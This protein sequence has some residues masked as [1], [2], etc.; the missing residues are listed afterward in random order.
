MPLPMFYSIFLILY[1]VL[2]IVW[3][4][5]LIHSKK[6]ICKVHIFMT[7]TLIFKCG[8]L[9][10]TI[11]DYLYIERYG[12]SLFNWSIVVNIISSLNN[13]FFYTTL[14]LVSMG[15]SIIKE[16]IGIRL[17]MSLC[18]L[19]LLQLSII[20]CGILDKSKF[21]MF[22]AY[23]LFYGISSFM[24]STIILI[25]LFI[26]ISHLKKETKVEGKGVL[27][28]RKLALYKQMSIVTAFYFYCYYPICFAVKIL[29]F[30]Y[31]FIQRFALEIL[32]ICYYIY[33]GFKF[34]P[35]KNNIYYMLA[36]DDSEEE[37]DVM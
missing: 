36:M 10:V 23:N 1:I 31:E 12:S 6:S 15:Y 29:P 25:V 19:I 37:E 35:V 20:A 26:T 14:F 11:A 2:T 33:V 22:S 5:Y 32:T 34:K 17:R 18:T 28:L 9:S 16:S 24:I 7:L 3:T 13:L 27:H 21:N 30:Q 4:I 8:Y